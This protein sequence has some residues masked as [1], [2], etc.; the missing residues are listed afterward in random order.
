M[1]IF[2]DSDNI[3]V[4]NT[5]ASSVF[6]GD[7]LV[8]PMD[9]VIIDDNTTLDT[10]EEFGDTSDIA[11]TFN[12]G[13]LGV[14]WGNATMDGKKL[15]LDRIDVTPYNQIDIIFSGDYRGGIGRL[16]VEKVTPTTRYL[17]HSDGWNSDGLGQALFINN[18]EIYYQQQIIETNRE[19]I[20]PAAIDEDIQI[21]FNGLE[22]Y[23]YV[24]RYIKSLIL[25]KV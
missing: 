10:L 12:R 1:P 3:A 11:S 9:V 21:V 22:G 6:Q 7:T 25:R 17:E 16:W 19:E 24:P 23:T 14:S 2:N 8:W 18:V 20:I 4:G 5:G 13:S 15:I